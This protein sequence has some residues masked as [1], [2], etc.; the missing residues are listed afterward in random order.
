MSMSLSPKAESSSSSITIPGTFNWYIKRLN[1]TDCKVREKAIQKIG[2][3]G[4]SRAVEPLFKVLFAGEYYVSERVEY[5]DALSMLLTKQQ[6]FDRFIMELFSSDEDTRKISAEVLGELGD[7]TAVEPLIKKLSDSTDS[8]TNY[9]VVRALGRLG[10]IRAFEPL[11][12]AAL[13]SNEGAFIL[14]IAEVLDKLGATKEQLIEIYSK[15]L[16]SLS[17]DD[18][19]SSAVKALRELGDTRIFER[20]DEIKINKTNR[21]IYQLFN[22]N[23]RN[24]G[25]HVMAAEQLG[26]IGHK[27]A[28]EPLIKAFVSNLG[29]GVSQACGNALNKLVDKGQLIE[30]YFTILSTTVSEETFERAIEQL[31]RLGASKERLEAEYIR[32][33]AS[34]DRG[35]IYKQ[36]SEKLLMLGRAKEL[37]LEEHARALSSTYSTVSDA[38]EHQLFM[39]MGMAGK[40]KHTIT[41]VEL[42]GFKIL[43]KMLFDKDKIVRIRAMNLLNRMGSTLEGWNKYKEIRK[44]LSQLNGFPDQLPKDINTD[45]YGESSILKASQEGDLAVVKILIDRGVDLNIWNHEGRTPLMLAVANEYV[46]VVEVLLENKANVN[47]KVDVSPDFITEMGER[48]ALLFMGVPAYGPSDP[49][50][51]TALDFVRNGNTNIVSMLL[52]AGAK[53]GQ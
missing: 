53:S 14:V 39:L 5:L 22:M 1:H 36:A 41:D 13:D 2:K 10:D 31:H 48:V 47:M 20:E 33:L 15:V 37:L 11:M 32:V 49:D 23:L 19:Y 6:L 17:D 18:K 7:K 38:A 35:G 24:S 4:D 21:F 43:R 9:Y 26:M 27:S 28:I 8:S 50:W 16:Q 40:V 46:E 52:D 45:A 44:S 12:K 3:R 25:D 42:A 34:T 29:Y 30:L 51:K